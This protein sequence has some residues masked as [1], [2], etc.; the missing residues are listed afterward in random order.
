MKSI[1]SSLLLIL[2][3]AAV[4][5]GCTKKFEA[6]SE[7]LNQPSPGKVPPGIVL[8][9]ILS[10][11]V[12][13]PGGDADKACQFICSNYVYYGN[14]EYWTGSAS[15]NYGDLNNTLQMEAEARRLAGSDNNPYHALGLFFRAFFFVNM[16]EKVGDLPMTEA[17]QGLNNTQPKYD[18]QKDI[19]KQS[20]LWLDSANIILG[21]LIKNGF[22]EFSGDF[23]YKER[24]N[25]PVNGG[26]GLDALVEWQKVVNS[27]KLRV[28]IELSKRADDNADLNI[29]Q[30]F[31]TI[32]NDP[33]TYPIF[34]SSADNLQYVYNSTYNYYPD[35]ITNYGNNQLRLNLAATLETTLGQLHD[36]RCM[37]LG[38]PARGLGHSDTSYASYVGAP[39]G[40]D[41]STMNALINSG[42]AN[43]KLSLYNRN[44]FYS[45]YT[46]EPTY[47]L[48]YPEICFCIAEAINRGWITGDAESW[49]EKGTEAQFAFYGIVDGSNTVVLMNAAGTE[50]PYPVQFKFADYF[51]QPA[52][53]YAGNN[54][55]GL[56]QIL[57]QK[58]LAYARNSGYQAY[59]QWR[60]TGVPAFDA[61]PG[62]GN[63][64][65]IPLRWQY[66]T[67]EITANNANLQAALQS[68]YGGNDDINA[69]M[70]LIK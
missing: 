5:A 44:H 58:Y 22:L 38:E 59:Y 46:A 35:N 57:T 55:T 54:S 10:D 24:I 17:L 61:G 19:F 43:S 53:K 7:N 1:K 39:S 21:G 12:V 50:I 51:N 65:V 69:K 52:V 60:R 70:W 28:L 32:I 42:L 37:V 8:K 13:F 45:G 48:S 4:A 9:S 15:L 34:S 67:N 66:P 33:A 68:Q 56:Q 29:P 2:V 36:L 62:T 47:I 40:M 18:T 64:G 27:Y 14:N 26:N 31:A 6:Y 3:I 20:L 25:N 23:Y 63:G 30:Q 16:T 11:L 41:L 49:Y